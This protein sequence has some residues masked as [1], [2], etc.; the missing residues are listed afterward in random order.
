MNSSELSEDM[1]CRWSELKSLIEAL[2]FDLH[3][4][5][6]GVNSAGSRFRR[7]LK[8][9][10]KHVEALRKL[11]IAKSKITRAQRAELLA[12]LDSDADEDD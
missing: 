5:S 7:G 1:L 2:E 12:R 8:D 9:A 6:I 4:H 10:K 3:Q 11:S